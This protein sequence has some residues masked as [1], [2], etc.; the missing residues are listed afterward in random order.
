MSTLSIFCLAASRGSVDRIIHDLKEANFSNTEIGALLFDRNL[1]N[2]R[3]RELDPRALT[4]AAAQ[5]AGP[6]RG[7]LA[8][9]AGIS[10]LV[11]P[12]VGSYIAAGP[13]IA[14]LHQV[15]NGTPGVAIA[16]GLTHLGMPSANAAHYERRIKTDSQ[17]LISVHTTNP[18]KILRAREIFTASNAPDICSTRG[19]ITPSV[20]PAVPQE[21]PSRL[22]SVTARTPEHQAKI[23]RP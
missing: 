3:A 13:I 10:R 14:A 19:A 15:R 9:V 1:E 2:D 23:L 11:V 8:W 7:G 6:I 21:W 22:G 4:G 5:S 18:N 16:R 20:V 17:I 12:G